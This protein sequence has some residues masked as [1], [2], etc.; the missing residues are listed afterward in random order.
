MDCRVLF[1][2]GCRHSL[3]LGLVFAGDFVVS[4]LRQVVQR[5]VCFSRQEIISTF[6]QLP[7]AQAVGPLALADLLQ[8]LLQRGDAVA[9][10]E[11]CKYPA[12]QQIPVQHVQQ[13]LQMAVQLQEH[14]SKSMAE[15]LL[16]LP[17]ASA[18]VS[19]SSCL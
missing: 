17:G 13:L 3:V 19:A 10:L 15:E 7:A 11:L 14:Y 9:A 8:Q 4:H 2:G 1:C 16:A 18:I 12:V 6:R 5:C